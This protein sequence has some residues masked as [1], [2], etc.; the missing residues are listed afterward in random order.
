MTWR[1]SVQRLSTTDQ[2]S[3]WSSDTFSALWRSQKNLQ[4]YHIQHT[5]TLCP[6][7]NSAFRRQLSAVDRRRIIMHPVVSVCLCVFHFCKQDISKKCLWISAK[8]IADTSYILPWKWLTYGTD[9][10][11]RLTTNDP[12]FAIFTQ[13]I[14]EAAQAVPSRESHY[15]N[16]P[17]RRLISTSLDARLVTDSRPRPLH[18]R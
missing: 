11:R 17:S 15:S 13:A 1:H 9:H 14:S 16:C 12:K 3:L 10:T 6:T 2:A 4:H 7:D 18:S 8:F 5:V